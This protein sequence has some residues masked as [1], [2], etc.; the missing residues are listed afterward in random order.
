[1]G[2]T[3]KYVTNNPH[4]RLFNDSK[5]FSTITSGKQNTP[6]S[7][8]EQFNL[9]FTTQS[10]YCDEMLS[11]VELMKETND[12]DLVVGEL[13]YL[14]SALVADKLSVPQILISA[15]PLSTPS[16]FAVGV[17]APLAYIPQISN[18]DNRISN[19]IDRGRNVLQ[20][21]LLHWYYMQDFCP[22]YGNI[23]AKYNITPNKSIHETLGRAD[24]IIGQVPFGLEH[25]RPVHP[26]KWFFSS[27]L[28]TLLHITVL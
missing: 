19:I 13:L 11:D 27:F 25:P 15:G 9:L 18:N 3:A 8:R 17:P 1:M 23:K 20:W 16:S 6:L 12:A 26:S 24:L 7:A 4:V 22:L 5:T 28:F 2:T 21:I 14:C 10:S